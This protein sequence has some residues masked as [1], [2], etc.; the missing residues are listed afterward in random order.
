MKKS[1]HGPE[2]SAENILAL[3]DMEKT[4]AYL[5][6]GRKF[7]SLTLDQL[8]DKWTTAFKAWCS[9]GYTMDPKES[10]DAAA[11]FGLRKIEPPYE[12]V[13]IEFAEMQEKIRRDSPNNPGVLAKIEE[14]LE[15]L[16]KP[17]N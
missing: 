4:R 7:E 2:I 16:K 1:G 8:G 15:S 5:E 11:E 6:G 10:D 12:R 3:D 17:G 14:L 13:A 9:S